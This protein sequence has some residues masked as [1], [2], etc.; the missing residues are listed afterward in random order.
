MENRGVLVDTSVI[1]EHLRRSKGGRSLLALAFEAFQVCCV[2]AVTV[3]E[4]EL[5]A[6]LAGRESDVA[7]LLPFLQVVPFGEA[8]AE[9][10]SDLQAALIKRN[11]RISHRDAMIAGTALARGLP[12]LT[13]DV[14]HFRRIPGIVLASVE[15]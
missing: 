10:T 14:E 12:L 3:Y 7:R 8:E 1:I 13:L 4:V 15:R 9:E 2:S 6:K 11:L 5:G